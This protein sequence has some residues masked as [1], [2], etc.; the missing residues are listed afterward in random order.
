MFLYQYGSTELVILDF[1]SSIDFNSNNDEF[2]INIV[3]VYIVFLVGFFLKLGIA[4]VHFYK[5]E[6]YKG[7]PF[8]TILFYTVYFFYIFFIFFCLVVTYYLNSLSFI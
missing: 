7:L 6:L 1:L 5:I 3:I 8:I 2:N 4:P